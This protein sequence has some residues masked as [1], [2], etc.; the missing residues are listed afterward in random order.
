MFLRLEKLQNVFNFEKSKITSVKTLK[1]LIYKV[2][3]HW[4]QP[5]SFNYVQNCFVVGYP[6]FLILED[7]KNLFK[8]LHCHTKTV[9]LYCL[10][11]IMHIKHARVIFIKNSEAFFNSYHSPC[12]LLDDSLSQIRD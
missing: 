9:L 3:A 4:A 10:N 5:T 7:V 6:T 8:V 11:E 12:S 2:Q 1:C